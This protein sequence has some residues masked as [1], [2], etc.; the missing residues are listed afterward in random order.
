[1]P[2]PHS[3]DYFTPLKKKIT[4]GGGSLKAEICCDLTLTMTRVCCLAPSSPTQ[5]G[6]QHPT[7]SSPCLTFPCPSALGLM[8]LSKPLCQL[9][10]KDQG[11]SVMAWKGL[12][13]LRRCSLNSASL[14]PAEQCNAHSAQSLQQSQ[15]S[16]LLP[17]HAQPHLGDTR[18]GFV[19]TAQQ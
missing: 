15:E 8:M 10:H 5:L 12:A 11:D 16:V 19:S 17:N 3:N 18:D 7:L 4:G 9:A 6:H 1:M 14:A 13:P 2:A